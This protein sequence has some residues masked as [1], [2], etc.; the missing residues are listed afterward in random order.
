MK[1]N[2]LTPK[3]EAFCQAYLLTGSATAAYREAYNASRMQPDTVHRTAHDLLHDPKITARLHT[4]AA[5]TADDMAVSRRQVENVLLSVVLAD[6]TDLLDFVDDFAGGTVRLKDPS[7]IPPHLRAAIKRISVRP[8]GSGTVELH[9]KL[10]AA[11]RLAR[12]K[13]WEDAPTLKIEESRRSYGELRI[14]FDDDD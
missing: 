9:D 7:R 13:G 10:G 4:L 6:A 1:S 11:Q 14:G 5:D 8:D 3:Q 2:D 12:M